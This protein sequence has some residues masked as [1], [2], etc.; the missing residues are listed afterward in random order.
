MSIQDW[1]E[2]DS[3]ESSNKKGSIGSYPESKVI[4]PE[5]RNYEPFEANNHHVDFN[6]E[7][8]SNPKVD[9]KS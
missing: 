8:D 6:H 7:T 5:S 3:T 4:E 9:S 2:K 1:S